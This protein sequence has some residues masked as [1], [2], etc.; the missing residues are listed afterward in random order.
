MTLVRVWRGQ[1]LGM[2]GAAAI[3]PVALVG[4]LAVLA[5]AGGFG[6][7]SALGQAFSGPALP[8]S[9]PATDRGKPSARP[10]P[11]ALAA[12]LSAPARLTATANAGASTA[13]D[14]PSS[15]AA[16]PTNSNG[17]A[18]VNPSSRGESPGGS[19]PGSRAQPHRAPGPSPTSGSQPTPQPQPTAAD[20]VVAAGT[21]V[22]SQVPGPAGPAAT[23][24]LRTAGSTLDSIAP[25]KSP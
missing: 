10:V 9:Q 11:A 14:A 17:A 20:G 24:A 5:L 22:T 18:P 2:V 3:V 13:Q 12:A 15:R 25:I 19:G 4:S 16:Q 23:K 7:L 21:S 1:L 6:G 8:A